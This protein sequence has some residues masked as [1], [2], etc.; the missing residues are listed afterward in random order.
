MAVDPD[1]VSQ[2]YRT[3]LRT[4]LIASGVPEHLWEG[5]IEY[6]TAR[7][8]TGEFLRAVLSNDLKEAVGRADDASGPALGAL[9]RFLYNFCPAPC[10]GSP[11]AV[12]AW[13]ENPE[14]PQEMFD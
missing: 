14:K 12:K 10:W 4:R 9:V 5:L 1:A 3:H 2:N 11:R 13:L 7:R 8:P 6:I